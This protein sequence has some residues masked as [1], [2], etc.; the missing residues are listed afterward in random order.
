MPCYYDSSRDVCRNRLSISRTL[1]SRLQKEQRSEKIEYS[2]EFELCQPNSSNARDSPPSLYKAGLFKLFTFL[3]Q[4]ER[5][6]NA[7]GKPNILH[8]L[9]RTMLRAHSIRH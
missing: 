8:T 7:F 3:K 4:S 1:I 2:R 5:L 6:R 9:S